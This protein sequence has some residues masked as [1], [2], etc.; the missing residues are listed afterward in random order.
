MSK[1]K[2]SLQTVLDWRVDQE[3]EAKMKLVQAQE[4]LNKE[5][6]QLDYL[7]A[8]NIRLKEKSLVTK[9]IH[10]MR[11]NDLYKRVLDDKII[12]Q[13]LVV[14]QVAANV[15]KAEQLL[16]KAHQNKKVM[17]KLEDKEYQRHL[18]LEKQ[19]DQKQIDEF[20]TIS[21]GRSIY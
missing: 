17:E 18:E 9:D 3:E 5:K 1:Y 11:N 8:E 21:F 20:S 14:E 12:K 2:F 4:Q 19:E 7:I 15:K 16:I 10:K 6:K 13:K